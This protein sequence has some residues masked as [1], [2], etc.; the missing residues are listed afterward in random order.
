M[1][2]R[3]FGIT[4][5]AFVLGGCAM[6][7]HSN[8][9]VFGT[10]TSVALS[11]GG[12]A[13]STPE[14]VVGYKRQEAVLMPLLA[15]TYATTSTNGETKL[16]PCPDVKTAPTTADDLAAI[17][18]C[19]YV[20]VANGRELDSYSVLASFGAKF[21]AKGAPNA[22]ASGGLAQYF[23]TGLAARR[24]AEK[25]GAA[26]VAT[27]SAAIVS[28]RLNASEEDKAAVAQLLDSPQIAAEVA[29]M[30][31][32]IDTVLQG[33]AAKDAASLPGHLVKLDK[34]LAGASPVFSMACNGKSPIACV[35]IIRGQSFPSLR[36]DAWAAAA[37]VN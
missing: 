13:T 8:M 15:N 11:V 4:A 22:S 16:W 21:D 26:A 37:K 30:Q 25:A 29:A 14:I 36:A 10:N 32:D 20:G 34:S 2:S 28:A 5:I 17:A 1:R 24:L 19:K 9:M 35:D 6:T 7:Q 31:Q 23:A 27:G 18:N 33:V 3:F 12:S